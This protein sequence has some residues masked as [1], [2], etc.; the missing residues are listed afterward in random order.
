[1]VDPE[2][3]PIP[4]LG[5]RCLSCGYLLA[6]LP[7]H[8]CP[9]CGRKIKIEEHIPPGDWPLVFLDGS[10][11]KVTPAVS[12]LMKTYQIPHMPII[13]SSGSEEIGAAFGQGHA[14]NLSSELRVPRH[15]FF[16]AID[17]LRRQMLGEPMPEPPEL[18]PAQHDWNCGKC[19]E[20]NP[21][22]FDVCWNCQAERLAQPAS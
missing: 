4:D 2:F 22:T 8:V 14:S 3:L 9:E 10:V 11:V 16:D 12:S 20:E 13:P 7:S 6:G 15:C 18:I 5:L 19:G 17:L 1:M 21:A